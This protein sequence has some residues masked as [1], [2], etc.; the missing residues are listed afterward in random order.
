MKWQDILTTNIKNSEIRKLMKIYSSLEEVYNNF[1]KLDEKIKIQ[2]E[3]CKKY[4]ITDKN[5][6]VVSYYDDEYPE[7]LKKIKDFPTFLYLKG[8]KLKPSKFIGI[9]GTRNNTSLGEKTC[10]KVIKGLSEYNNICIVSGMAKGID[11]IAHRCAI[12]NFI[13]TIAILPTDIYGCYPIENIKLKEL[14][15]K[16]GTIISEFKVGTK[17]T[18]ANFVIRN[19]IIAG[20]SRLIYIPQTYIN[21]GSLITAKYASMYD[22][23]I[24]TSPGDIF[25]KSFEGC[26]DMIVKNKAKLIRDANDIAYEYGWRKKSEEVFSNSGITI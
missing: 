7:Y 14:I 12:E 8:S 6:R 3:Q 15:Q 22:R 19:R 4:E 16:N 17:L 2:L 1:D 24:Y 23:E 18:K 26:N 25:D 13:P 11:S 9:V 5:L 20:I 10:I 21:G